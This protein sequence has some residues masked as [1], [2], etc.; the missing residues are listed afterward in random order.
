MA[1]LV[2]YISE[3]RYEFDLDEE[4]AADFRTAQNDEEND[5][6]HEDDQGR[7]QG[8]HERGCRAACC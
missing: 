4:T 8:G 5:H 7:D 1:K 6:D 3:Q 2:V